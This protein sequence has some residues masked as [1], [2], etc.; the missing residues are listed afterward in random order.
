MDVSTVVILGAGASKPYGL[1]LGRELRDQ[2]L[3]ISMGDPNTKLFGRFQITS[4]EFRDFCSDLRTSAFQ[5]VDAF[6]E[7]RPKWLKVGKIAMAMVLDGWEKEERLL[8]PKQP[9]DHWYEALWHSFRATSWASLKRTNIKIVSFNYDRTLEC[10]LSAVISNNYPIQRKT[11]ATWL[12]EHLILH[13]HG[14]LGEYAGEQLGGFR[15]GQP[16]RYARVLDALNSITVISEAESKAKLFSEIRN[17]I[18]VAER[19]IF[20][21]FGFH[22]QNMVRL[23]FPEVCS[24]NKRQMVSATKKGVHKI[25]WKSLCKRYFGRTFVDATT[26]PTMSKIVSDCIRTK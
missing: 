19:V 15:I 1:P 13:P 6:L 23:G 25:D 22:E 7:K 10:Y 20:L 24:S 4:D 18:R 5:T 11:A 8:P 17:Y 12:K 21:G 3:S 14:T 16:D 9:K 2:V 26:W